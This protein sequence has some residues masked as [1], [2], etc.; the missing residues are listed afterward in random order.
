[1]T[2][3][4][5]TNNECPICLQSYTNKNKR[6]VCSCKNSICQNCAVTIIENN[7][8]NSQCPYCHEKYS[9]RFIL[10]AYETKHIQKYLKKYN[11][12]IE[13]REEKLTPQILPVIERI[14]KK[15]EY[16]DFRNHTQ[17]DF[18]YVRVYPDSVIEMIISTLTQTNWRNHNPHRFLKNINKIRDFLNILENNIDPTNIFII[19]STP[20]K[21]R[22][23]YPNF[24]YQLSGTLITNNLHDVFMNVQNTIINKSDILIILPHNILS[25][26][27]Q[28]ASD[29]FTSTFKKYLHSEYFL[30]DNYY[31]VHPHMKKQKFETN[32]K[33]NIIH[34]IYKRIYN[35]NKNNELT[36]YFKN[37]C[38][39]PNCPGW[40]QSQKRDKQEYYE[41]IICK[42]E[43]CAQCFEKLINYYENIS[44]PIDSTFKTVPKEIHKCKEEDVKNFRKLMENSKPCP[45]CGEIINKNGGCS[46][47]FCTMC[48]CCFDWN[49][50]KEITTFFHNPHHQE[51]LA[52]HPQIT[53]QI[54]NDCNVNNIKVQN[55]YL[56]QILNV[57]NNQMFKIRGEYDH[58]IIQRGIGSK[59]YSIFK[60]NIK[61]LLGEITPKYYHKKLLKITNHQLY[62]QSVYSVLVEF[63]NIIFD[64]LRHQQRVENEMT[65]K[66]N[67]IRN[68]ILH[69]HENLDTKAL[70]S[71]IL[72]AGQTVEELRNLIR[73]AIERNNTYLQEDEKESLTEFYV[74]LR[75]SKIDVIDLIKEE[76][77]F[78]NELL[79]KIA[80]GWYYRKN[81]QIEYP[82][83]NP[84][85]DTNSET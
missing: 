28:F 12:F 34:Y 80:K 37:K 38:P 27:R 53:E 51:W 60:L 46:Q 48:H 69:N 77:K 61:K 21:R 57:I 49:T 3:L 59:H 73:P 45:K 74:Y 8:K 63:E 83:L 23:K 5:D 81:I 79:M 29:D 67:W 41:C 10:E 13:E 71:H 66:N 84:V 36:S 22:R 6:L 44:Y 7:I 32:Y 20:C 50:G 75:N 1:M 18:C 14:Q 85:S 54:T 55:V 33:R 24:K 4:N 35:A 82:F 62:I 42:N 76:T 72:H 25:Q 64:I 43:F 11:S 58:E 68:I 26:H 2:G 78:T 30:D 17:K 70:D 52:T 56:Q 9:V 19:P 31:N 16:W 39:T 65:K 15:E 47:M 40:L